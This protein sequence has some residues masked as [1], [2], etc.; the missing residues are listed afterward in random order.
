[1]ALGAAPATVLRMIVISGA[2]IAVIG[3]GVGLVG[4]AALTR[5]LQSLLYGTEPLDPV[6][7]VAMSLILFATGLLASYLPARKAAAVDPMESLRI[8]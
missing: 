5:L 6:T 8:E 1:M 2:R 4:S 3:L 7:F